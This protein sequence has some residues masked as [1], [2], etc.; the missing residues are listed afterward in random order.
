M[1]GGASEDAAVT[2]TT[3]LPRVSVVVPACAD[4]A[5]LVAVLERVPVAHEVVVVHD[6]SSDAAVA[7]ARDSR[8]TVR[9]ATQRHRD[10]PG[11]LEAGIAAATGDIVVTLAADGSHRPEDIGR[12]VTAL[13]DG[14]D[15]ATGSRALAGGGSARITPLRAAGGGALTTAANLLFRVRATD[16]AYGY[17]AFWSA[18]AARLSGRG[19]DAEGAL[20]LPIRAAR[21]GLRVTEV[22]CIEDAPAEAS[23][24]GRPVHDGARILRAFLA[25]CLRG[26][27]RSDRR[28]PAERP[29][30]A[31]G[32]TA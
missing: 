4:A 20:L 17:T 2:L 19:A 5:R 23:G 16:V 31:I 25:E 32:E 6:G 10:T 29:F 7:A 22:A 24:R 9:V 15:V 27:R 13:C 30:Q 21:A 11:A 28:T 12:L 14:A 1:P 3:L 8:A 26:D 18:H